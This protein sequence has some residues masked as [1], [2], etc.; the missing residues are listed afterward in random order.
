MA[1]LCNGNMAEYVPDGEPE[2]TWVRA[3]G[4]GTIGSAGYGSCVGMVLYNRQRRSGVVAHFSGS[5]SLVDVRRDAEE[6]LGLNCRNW[7][8]RGKWKSWVFGGQSLHP[9]SQ[10]DPMTVNTTKAIIDAVRQVLTQSDC[11]QVTSFD[12]LDPEKRLAQGSPYA[13][14]S[15]VR[16]NVG[17]ATIS[18]P[19]EEE[20]VKKVL[21]PKYFET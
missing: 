11:F 15:A 6:I 8:G 21:K 14:H 18:W 7:H 13:G 3:Q 5:M 20:D 19:G 10:V 2:C 1:R 9:R 17:T 12:Q 16:L 4:G